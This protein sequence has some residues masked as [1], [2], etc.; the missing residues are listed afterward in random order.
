MGDRDPHEGPH[1]IAAME[2]VDGWAVLFET[3]TDRRHARLVLTRDEGH[4]EVLG[5]WQGEPTDEW[6]VPPSDLPE[7]ICHVIWH[8]TTNTPPTLEEHG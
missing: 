2:V 6:G 1:Q 4:G 7:I 8:V 5:C 3:A